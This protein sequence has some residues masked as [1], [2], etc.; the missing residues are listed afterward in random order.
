MLTYG[1]KGAIAQFADAEKSAIWA[2]SYEKLFIEGEGRLPTSSLCRFFGIETPEYEVTNW[3]D[4]GQHVIAGEGG[5]SGQ[6]LG[7]VIYH[8]PGYTPDEIAIWDP[9]ERVIFVGDTMYEWAPIFF[10]L[11]GSLRLYSDT[12][13]RLKGLVEPWNAAASDQNC[14]KCEFVG[15]CF[16]A[17]INHCS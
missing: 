10:P 9:K 17:E 8:T 13:G 6:D 11:E 15:Q 1:P 16:K 2:S 5:E 4:D 12:L 14:G 7:L 3:A